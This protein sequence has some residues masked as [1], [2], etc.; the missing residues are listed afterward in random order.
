MPP[1]SAS[2]ADATVSSAPRPARDVVLKVERSHLGRR[3]ESRCGDQRLAWALAQRLALPE[4]VGRVL[5]GR[6]LEL[7]GIEDFLQPTLRRLMPDPFRF[8]DMDRAVER[9][10]AAIEGGEAIAVFGD[11]D[12]DGATSSALLKR[13]LAAAGVP[14]RVYIPDRVRDGYGPNAPALLRL[15]SEGV[16]LVITVDCGTTAYE[17]LATAAEAGLEVIVLDHHAA[18]PRLPPVHAMVNPNRLDED[19]AYGQLAAVGVT[20]VFLVAL[21][22][23]LREAGWYARNG[24]GEP[25]LR[26]WLDLVALGTVCDVVPLTG[27]NR[28]FVAQGLKV[29]AGRRNAGLAALADVARL[30]Q[31]PGTYHA[32][33]LLGPRVNAGGRVGRS[34]L[35]ARLLA[36][37]DPGEAAE[38][39]AELDGYNSERREIERAVLDQAMAQV[40]SG[41]ALSEGLVLAAGE[42]WHPGVIGIVAGR[43][44]ERTNL[45]A[46]VVALEGEVGKGSGRSVPGVDLGAAVIAARQMDLLENGGG[47][48]MAAGLTVARDR[49]AELRAFLSERL[50]R[51]MAEIDY[52]PALGIDAVL[53]PGAARAD[54]VRRLEEIGPFGVGNPEPRF[55]VP[56]AQVLGPQVVGEA[57]VRATLLGSDGVR[58]KAIAFRALDGAL[59]KALLRGSGLPLHLAGKLRLDAW[60]GG[61]AVQFII[62]DAAPVG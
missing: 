58:L 6:G 2:P 24:R 51:R 46:L 8:Q 31:A 21:N 23:A 10:R 1:P 52:R 4:A 42:G 18:E 14:L 59:G 48:P 41:Q 28:A 3:W 9:L 61:D 50:A 36:C 38:L 12:V 16:S 30:D 11:Y 43:L 45:P 54:L 33:F 20:F 17:A 7:E 62:E 49:L 44:K 57:H 55:V 39:A 25:D 56:A 37:D 60:A 47:H 34:E 13:F 27:L 15:K 22:R 35:G 26:R 19:G 29:M 40:E 32:G 5:A 53:Q